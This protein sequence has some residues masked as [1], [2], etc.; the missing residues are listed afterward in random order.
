VVL[1]RLNLEATL[2]VDLA[3][4]RFAHTSL[5][6]K[7][8][9]VLLCSLPPSIFISLDTLNICY[10]LWLSFPVPSSYQLS[11]LRQT[12]DVTNSN[13]SP[14]NPLLSLNISYMSH[15][16]YAPTW[17]LSIWPQLDSIMVCSQAWGTARSALVTIAS[18]PGMNQ[19]L[20]HEI[21]GRLSVL[22]VDSTIQMLAPFRTSHLPELLCDD[23]LSDEHINAGVRYVN[24]H[25][26]CTPSICV[27]DSYFLGYLQRNFEHFGTW[28]PHRPVVLD[29]LI[30][31]TSITEL[32][33]PVHS[34]GHWTL[35]HV[36]ITTKC[37]AYVDTLELAV[38]RPPW[39]TIDLVNRWLSSILGTN[40]LLVPSCRPFNIGSQYD[41][42]SCGVAVLS[43]IAH[44]ALG[45]SYIA[46]CQSTA[47]QHR[48]KW[49]LHFSNCSTN[50]VCTIYIATQE[51]YI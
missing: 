15:N 48:L 21:L 35:L 30:A 2:P 11:Q 49:A 14:S 43:T 19:M 27:L 44:Y 26:Q 18:A 24:L 28:S 37:Y 31:S 5:L 4:A 10:N 22:P 41:G 23:W 17:V 29:S 12:L 36:N 47:K 20:A 16:V 34:P 32:L 51:A 46:W 45:G 40:I 7:S 33:I 1:E 25:P 9:T 39:S 42:H 38:N 8:V 50:E 6:P 3:I 13:S